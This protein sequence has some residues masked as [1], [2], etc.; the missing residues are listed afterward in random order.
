MFKKRIVPRGI[1]KMNFICHCTRGGA[2]ILGEGK[3]PLRS[4]FEPRS[5]GP[6]PV[7]LDH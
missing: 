1:S 3:L 7:I 2:E 4:I 6:K 5:T